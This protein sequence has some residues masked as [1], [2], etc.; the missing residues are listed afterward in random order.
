MAAA[1]FE[2]LL[3]CVGQAWPVAE[4]PRAV[5]RDVEYGGGLTTDERDELLH[6]IA[7][8][9]LA[10]ESAVGLRDVPGEEL[11]PLS[12]AGNRAAA[13]ELDRRGVELP[14]STSI[15]LGRFRYR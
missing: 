12:P 6:R 5:R 4:A 8:D 14:M 1:T 10:V 2:Y 3:A 11:V 7:G 13:A 15:T 9:L